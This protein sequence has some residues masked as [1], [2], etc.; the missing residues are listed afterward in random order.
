MSRI[1]KEPIIVPTAAKIGVEDGVFDARTGV[2]HRQTNAFA[3]TERTLTARHVRGG[4]L[5]GPA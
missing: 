4:D 1:G 3:P 5:Q 2:R